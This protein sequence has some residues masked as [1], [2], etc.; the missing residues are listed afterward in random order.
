MHVERGADCHIFRFRIPV[1]NL[2]SPRCRRHGAARLRNVCSDAGLVVMIL[3]VV[4]PIK[5]AIDLE[6]VGVRICAAELIASAVEAEDEL[7]ANMAPP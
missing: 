6:D 1:P 4:G 5:H 3:I 7:L 2:F